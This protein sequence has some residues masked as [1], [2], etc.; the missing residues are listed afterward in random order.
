M[1]DSYGDICY[2]ALEDLLIERNDL[3]RYIIK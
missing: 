2:E 3:K 1:R